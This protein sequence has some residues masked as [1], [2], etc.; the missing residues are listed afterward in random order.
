MHEP[1]NQT[2][3]YAPRLDGSAASDNF[4]A[5]LAL[6]AHLHESTTPPEY[7]PCGS[8]KYRGQFLVFLDADFQYVIMFVRN[9]HGQDP[10]AAKNMADT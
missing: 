10:E 6:L 4:D 3:F 1:E 8:G 5:V 9:L 7:E 2:R